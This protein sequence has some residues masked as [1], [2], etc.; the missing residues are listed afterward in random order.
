MPENMPDIMP[1]NNI[2]HPGGLRGRP[3]ERAAGRRV[4]T[5]AA[6]P[7][8]VNREA[9]AACFGVRLD[10]EPRRRDL[11]GRAT[12]G[13]PGAVPPSRADPVWSKNSAALSERAC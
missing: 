1:E 13:L 5:V 10:P 8:L 3:P 9:V 7:F 11:A 12:G 6:H 2:G 4:S